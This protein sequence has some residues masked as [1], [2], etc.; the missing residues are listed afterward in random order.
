MF[1]SGGGHLRKSRMD[2]G[3]VGVVAALL[4]LGTLAVYSAV[5]PLSFGDRV[6]RVQ[7][8]ALGIGALAF[9]FGW[10]L[11]YQVYQDQLKI[12]YAGT[13]IVLAIVLFAGR[14]MRGTTG[15]FKIGF[16]NFQ[17]S[18]IARI[19][20]IFAVANFL[21]RRG[22]RIPEFSTPILAY[23]IAAPILG[24]IIAQPD[25]SSTIVAFPTIFCMLFA[26]GASVLQLAGLAGLGALAAGLPILW[27]LLRLKPEI[28]EAVPAFSY[29][30]SLQ[31]F[32]WPFVLT[33]IGVFAGAYALWFVLD[34]F[35]IVIPRVYMTLGALFLLLGLTAGVGINS[36]LKEYQRNRLVAFVD[37]TL[38]PRGSGYNSLQARIAIGSGGVA[39]KGLF[40]GTQSQLG[41][42]PERHTDFIL[43]VVGEELG[44]IGSWLLLALYAAFLLRILYVAQF[45]RD[46]FGYLVCCGLASMYGSHLIINAGMAVGFLPVAGVQLPLIS[47][48]GS[49]LVAS[50]WAIGIVESVYSRRYATV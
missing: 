15:W 33:A 37:P 34:K 45:S 23:L 14:H 36:K 44:L 6:V 16:L 19:I 49:S 3:L 25:L 21:D 43:T 27:T 28:I 39:G 9:F 24:L 5:L 38:D 8:I 41:F 7:A 50:L 32:G 47:Y 4:A 10:A 13:L 17:P 26:A 40:R 11:N 46:G 20:V 48:G 2:W 1:R 31:S 35:F 29:I 22:R 42:V 30:L 12:G 18:E